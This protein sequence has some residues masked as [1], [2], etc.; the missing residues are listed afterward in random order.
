MK[1]KKN[2][3][4]IVVF[5]L[6]VFAYASGGGEHSANVHHSFDWLGFFGKVFNSTVLF[7][8]L[9][10]VLKKPISSFLSKKV[11]DVKG[12]IV[13][14]E[15][16]IEDARNELS[17]IL[18]RLEAMEGDIKELNAQAVKTGKIEKEKLEK[19]A[20]GEADKIME[21]SKEEINYK[22]ELSIK[23]LRTRIAKM[24]IERFKNSFKND[25]TKKIHEQIINENIEISGD[26]IASYGASEVSK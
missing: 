9:Y 11:S 26:V 7:G 24:T 21:L 4:F 13:E 23:G 1:I 15:E 17:G 20:K 18:K 10:Y 22:I 12:D 5:F 16:K 6:T 8:G 25:L 3:I 2:I 19:F 14:R